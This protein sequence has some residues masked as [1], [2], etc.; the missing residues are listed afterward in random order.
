[1]V[2]LLC[3]SVTRYPQSA[4]A[5]RPFGATAAGCPRTLRP[6]TLEPERLPLAERPR[7]DPV[8]AAFTDEATISPPNRTTELTWPELPAVAIEVA[9]ADAE[10]ASDPVVTAVPSAG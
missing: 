4:S 8:A 6:E 10:V 9:L 1:V 3:S 5:T 7:V 2:P